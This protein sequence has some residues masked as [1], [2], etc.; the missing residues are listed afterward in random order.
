MFKLALLDILGGLKKAQFW[1]YMAWQEIV[2]RYRRSV[3]GPFWITAS[4]AIYVLSISTVFATLFNQDIKHYIIYMALGILV[5]NFINQTIIEAA[6]SFISCA[7]FIKQINIEKSVFIFQTIA[8]NFYFFL[9]N[10][11]ILVICLI[12]FDSTL[13][14]YTIG[15]AL[16]GL[17]LLSFNLFFLSLTLSCVCTRFMDLRQIIVSILQIGFLITPVMWIPT[18][19]MRSKAFLLE[20]NPLYHFIDFIR[21]SLLPADFPPAVMHPSIN[22]LAV[23]TLVN[24]IVGFTVFA[25]SRTKIPYWV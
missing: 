20:W 3:L 24:V 25:K 11:V 4:T 21:F 12:F 10:A 15:K 7:G 6:D 17:W 13:T 1:S 2:I 23:F 16:F 18:E 5:W 22:Y 9:H 19:T 14:V 8:R